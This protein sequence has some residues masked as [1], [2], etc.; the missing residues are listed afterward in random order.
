MAEKRKESRLLELFKTLNENFGKMYW[1]PAD[2]LDE[3]VIGAILTQNTSWKNV[4]KAISVLK[5][6]NMDNFET[7]LSLDK[8]LLESLIRPAGFYR[9]KAER[10]KTAARFFLKNRF[11]DRDMLLSLNGIGKE[12]ADSILLYGF[13]KPVFVVD[14]YTKRI[15]T[16]HKIITNSDY[17]SV[18]QLFHDNLSKSVKL[19]NQY[20]ALI[21]K[22]AK[23]YC[24]K[25]PICDK[26]PLLSDL[27]D[28][29]ISPLAI[30]R[31]LRNKKL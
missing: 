21:V 10:L 7:I 28:N 4:E 8:N 3:M 31:P 1:W 9:Q 18:Q 16:R 15:L 14:A 6:D 23:L 19:F 5:K 27:I 13:N 26:C 12:T 22:T 20:H 24:K 30:M 17:D 11:V 2:S 25:K 29:K